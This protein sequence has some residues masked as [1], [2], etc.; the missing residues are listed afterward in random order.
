MAKNNIY[1]PTAVVK[2]I[3]KSVP[4][5]SKTALDDDVARTLSRHR[6]SMSLL[7]TIPSC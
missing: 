6:N 3:E 1:A 2:W 4:G 5:N 7:R